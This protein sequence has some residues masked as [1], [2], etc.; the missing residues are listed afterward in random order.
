MRAIWKKQ[1]E[2]EAILDTN[3]N[4]NRSKPKPSANSKPSSS[5]RNSTGAAHRTAR[6]AQR[7]SL[8][9][10]SDVFVC[11]FS[12]PRKLTMPERKVYSKS[13]QAT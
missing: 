9:N 3:P 5:S 10:R 13:L 6:N 8:L 7:K 2:L 4:P 11:I 1:Q 12:A